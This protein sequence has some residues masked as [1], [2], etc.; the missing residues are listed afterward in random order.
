MKTFVLVL[1]ATAAIALLGACDTHPF[2]QT[3]VLHEKYQ[4]HGEH[5]AAE[6]GDKAA[7]HGAAEGHG[8]AKKEH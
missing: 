5:G 3:K 4:E 2:E 6:H 8:E 1:S 7:E